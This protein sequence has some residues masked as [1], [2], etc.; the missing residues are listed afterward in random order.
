ME[1]DSR[2]EVR[3]SKAGRGEARK[4]AH[5]RTY[6]Y[7]FDKTERERKRDTVRG[8]VSVCVYVCIQERETDRKREIH[9]QEMCLRHEVARSTELS[10]G[11]RPRSNR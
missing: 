3:R 7:T 2:E 10:A 1:T 9:S 8:G 6:T 11:M 5:T 4:N